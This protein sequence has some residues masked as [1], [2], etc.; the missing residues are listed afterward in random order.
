MTF[1]VETLA[2]KSEQQIS[3]IARHEATHAKFEHVKETAQ[4]RRVLEKNADALAAHG[5]SEGSTAYARSWW[6]REAASYDQVSVGGKFAVNRQNSRE[7]MS[8][9]NETYAELVSHGK[10]LG[11][12]AE[13]HKL[14]TKTWEM[15]RRQG[16]KRP[17]QKADLAVLLRK[18]QEEAYWDFL[19]DNDLELVEKPEDAAF[20]RRV[21]FDGRTEIYSVSRKG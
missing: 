21:Y 4:M 6:K 8:A 18:K 2:G 15:R 10:A 3:I 19:L 7:F 17:G 13:V 12:Y 9:V 14:V 5:A 16:K 11:P 1:N 20:L